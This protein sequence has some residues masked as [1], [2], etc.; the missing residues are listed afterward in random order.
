MKYYQWNLLQK[1]AIMLQLSYSSNHLP[2]VPAVFPTTLYSYLADGVGNVSGQ[3]A[4][5]AL[6]QGYIHWLSGRLSKIQ[7][8]DNN[9]SHCF[10]CCRRL[11]MRPTGLYKVFLLLQKEVEGNASIARATCECAAG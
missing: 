10:V 7:F 4:F 6:T 3:G 1:S 9:P 8:N 11:S 5:R 2:K